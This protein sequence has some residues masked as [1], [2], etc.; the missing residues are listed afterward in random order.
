MQLSFTSLF[1]IATTVSLALTS[2]VEGKTNKHHRAPK[3]KAFDHILQIWFE[4]QVNCHFWSKIRKKMVE[5]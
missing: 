2:S 1:V 3:G 5:I 4:N